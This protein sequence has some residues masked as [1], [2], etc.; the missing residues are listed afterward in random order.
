MTGGLERDALPNRL[1]ENTYRLPL[2]KIETSFLAFK[3][4]GLKCLLY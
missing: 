2:S 3:R 1:E 4:V